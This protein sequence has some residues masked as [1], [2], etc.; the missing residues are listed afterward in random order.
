ML[1][2]KLQLHRQFL[3]IVELWQDLGKGR[4]SASWGTTEL[5]EQLK[6]PMKC[7]YSKCCK[8]CVQANILHWNSLAVSQHIVAWVIEKCCLIQLMYFLLL[9]VTSA[10]SKGRERGSCSFG[11]GVIKAEKCLSGAGGPCSVF[12]FEVTGGGNTHHNFSTVFIPFLQI[13]ALYIS[14]VKKFMNN[15]MPQGLEERVLRYSL[16]SFAATLDVFSCYK[17]CSWVMGLLIQH[18]ASESTKG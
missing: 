16:I 9:P 4:I 7:N 1:T 18:P 8:C 3:G 10:A 17:W 11:A 13:S 5:A 12:I 6:S 15:Y 2:V 14:H